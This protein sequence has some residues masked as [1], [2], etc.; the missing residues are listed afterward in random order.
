MLPPVMLPVAEICPG[1]ITLPTLILPVADSPDEVFTFPVAVINPDALIFAPETLPVAAKYPAT[2]APADE[3]TITSG[4]AATAI[5]TLPPETGM[6]TLLVPLKI[7]VTARLPVILVLPVI[8]KSP[9][10]AT[11]LL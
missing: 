11:V 10:T 2:F 8:D 1:V 4:V 5:L 6:S 3:I 9:I 7:L